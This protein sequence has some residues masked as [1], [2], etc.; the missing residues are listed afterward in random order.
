M[1]VTFVTALTLGSVAANPPTFNLILPTIA[2]GNLA[3][4]DIIV[5]A[6]MS[7]NIV[8]ASNEIA[9]P[10]DFT[11]KSTKIEVDSATA[12]DD[13]R[14]A[15]FYKRAVSGDSGATVT[16]S[17]AGT[18][19]L[20]LYAV[21]S[22]WRGA[23]NTGDPFDTTAVARAGSATA[24]DV[25]VFPAYDPTATDVHV[26]YDG[27]KADDSTD[28]LANFTNDST[29]FTIRDDQETTTGTDTTHGIWS[30]DRNGNAL[31]AIS[32]TVNG[33]DGSYIGYSFALLPA[34]VMITS[35]AALT[36]TPIIAATGTVI[37]PVTSTAALTVAPSVTAAGAESL[38]GT[39]ALT[40]TPVLTATG[41]ESLT[42]TAALIVT[43]VVVAAGAESLSGTAA[44]VIAPVVTAAGAESLSST[45]ALTVTPIVTATGAESLTGTAALVVVPEVV[46]A[47][48][49]NGGG[50]PPDVTS[51]AALTVAPVLTAAGSEAI[52]GSAAL[53]V[54]PV[55]VGAG[56]ESLTGT[57]ALTVVPVVAGV[58]TQS[59]VGPPPDVISTAQLVIAPYVLATAFYEA[60]PEIPQPISLEHWERGVLRYRWGWPSE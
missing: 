41:Q 31:N 54:T 13:M 38:T 14:T 15:L 16:I 29:T 56:A 35:T 12:A 58:A 50:P 42:G 36:I 26:I 2:S 37:N 53:T 27:W 28:P 18:D 7:K 52:S 57:A 55:L 11:E 51:T 22:I 4:D 47:A 21:A 23:V 40:V 33:T 1:A 9:T 5:I 3:V 45:A 17:R 34:Q 59:G 32:A 8:E 10:T 43:P 46:G 44:L 24:G 39:A 30:A 48:E 6:V 49:V 25:I 19:T 60:P 20:G